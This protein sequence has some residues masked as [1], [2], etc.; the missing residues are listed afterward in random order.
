MAQQ[1]DEDTLEE[2]EL[3]LSEDPKLA[4]EV[5]QAMPRPLRDHPDLRLLE[6]E[7]H[8]AL[9]NWQ[10]AIEALERPPPFDPEDA[11]AHHLLGVAYG[12]LGNTARRRT[13]FLR[14]WTLDSEADAAQPWLDDEA[15]DEIARLARQALEELPAEYREPLG[16]VLVVL[17]ERPSR[18][19]VE[20][21]FDPRAYGLFEGLDHAEHLNQTMASQVT[22]IV[23]FAANLLA[24]F[25]EHE[26]LAQEVRITVLHEVGHY[27]GLDEDDM[28]RLGLD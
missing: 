4:L 10:Q 18:E 27:F 25:P 16:D 15:S 6:A 20:D 14:T 21:G 26:E 13:H 9:D 23:L 19:L 12:E 22:R 8:A 24:D 2:I 28:V 11:D 17:E 1:T 7:A 3:L 5:L